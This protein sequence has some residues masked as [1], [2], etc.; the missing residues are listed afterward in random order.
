MAK[1]YIYNL[2]GIITRCFEEGKRAGWIKEKT[3]AL[4]MTTEWV[5]VNEYELVKHISKTTIGEL[6]EL[7]VIRKL[8]PIFRMFRELNNDFLEIDQSTNEE[9]RRLNLR[10]NP[11]QG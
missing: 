3:T 6:Y 9:F 4:T 8:A 11:P 1:K 7:E 5:I 2:E 10:R